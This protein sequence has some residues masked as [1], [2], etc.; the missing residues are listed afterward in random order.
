P[1]LSGHLLNMG[2]CLF[3]LFSRKFL[4]ISK[5]SPQWWMRISPWWFWLFISVCILIAHHG[6]SFHN[7]TLTRLG[8]ISGISITIAAGIL[9]LA[10]LIDALKR[11]FQP[12][13]LL[14]AS[15]LVLILFYGI[16]IFLAN[17]N[18]LT[19]AYPDMYIF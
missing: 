13:W 17:M 14:F 11:S 4:V 9:W 3:L 8:Y 12:A 19:L 1:I 16:N 10:Y 18:V 15:R 7:G 2:L 5:Q 6:Y